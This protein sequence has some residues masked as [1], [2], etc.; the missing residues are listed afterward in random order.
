MKGLLLALMLLTS[1]LGVAQTSTD[2][3]IRSLIPNTIA[4]RRPATTTTLSFDI[5]AG[6]FPPAQYPARYLA[7]PQDFSLFSSAATPWIA[8]LEI[9]SQPDSQGRTISTNLVSFRVNGG[10]WIKATGLPQV[11]MSGVGATPGWVPLKL[12]VALD[13]EGGEPG[14]DYTFD[15]AFT[16]VVLP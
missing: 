12:E 3:T 10:P 5:N 6:N 9:L 7:Q 15:L 16:A 13:L 8:Q 4:I 11:I 14:G 1:G 2:G